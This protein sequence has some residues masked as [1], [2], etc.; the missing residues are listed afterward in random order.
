M[1]SSL[2]TD[3]TQAL[4]FLGAIA[5]DE[6]LTFQTFPEGPATDTPKRSARIL[7][8]SYASVKDVLSDLNQ[9]GH[10]IFFMVNQGD[11]QGRSARNVQKVRAHFVDLDGAP[12]DPLILSE[13]PPQ[14]VVESST[15]KWHAYWLIEDCPLEQFKPRQQA[16]AAHFEGDSAVCDLPRVMRVPGFWHLKKTPFQT[17]LHIRPL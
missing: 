1:K 17:R 13:A 8:G 3:H 9:A 6:H 11:L 5:P 15:N 12:L 14:I 10:G 2:I 7:H 4:A 16:L